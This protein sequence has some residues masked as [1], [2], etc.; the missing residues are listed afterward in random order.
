MHDLAVQADGA[1]VDTVEALSKS[2]DGEHPLL[3]AFREHHALQCGFCTPGMIMSS[4]ELLRREPQPSEERIRAWL[5]GNFCRCTGYQHIVDAIGAAGRD[6]RPCWC[7][8]S[9]YLASR[10]DSSASPLPGEKTT[11]ISGDGDV[12]PTTSGRPIRPALCM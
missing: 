1:A 12:S 4:L 10:A 8:R 5:K 9:G 7:D 6:D 3:S 11:I 2:G